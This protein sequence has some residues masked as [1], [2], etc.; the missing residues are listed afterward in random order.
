M[1]LCQALVAEYQSEADQDKTAISEGRDY[2]ETVASGAQDCASKLERRVMVMQHE[3]WI[4]NP[5]FL[6]D[7]GNQSPESPVPPVPD[8]ET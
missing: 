6:L 5:E 2:I 3:G 7:P 4:P 8:F 1:R